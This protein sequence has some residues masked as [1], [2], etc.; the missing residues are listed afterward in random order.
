MWTVVEL[1]AVF[2]VGVQTPRVYPAAWPRKGV[3]QRIE[4]GGKMQRTRGLKGW[5]SMNPKDTF[6][7]LL[8]ELR[9]RFGEGL[10]CV[11]LFGSRARGTA[12]AGSDYDLLVVAEE[13]PGD[14]VKRQRALTA[15]LLPVV[16]QVPGPVAFV[17]K[18]P[19]EF[20]SNLTPLL[21]DVCVEGICLW[22]AEFFESYRRRALEALRDSGLRRERLGGRT[23]MWVFTGRP[24][25][26]WE[27]TWDGFRERT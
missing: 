10:R 16:D 2:A 13:L 3:W 4:G 6:A 9:K 17:G 24:P 1:A 11:V 14:P 7:P 25:R 5:L 21:L 8:R 15:A 12:R 20:A 22:G 23:P 26:D 19:E 27:L 18:T